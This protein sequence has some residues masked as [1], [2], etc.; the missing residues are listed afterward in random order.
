[1]YNSIYFSIYF[2]I[3][4]HIALQDIHI[5]MNKVKVTRLNILINFAILKFKI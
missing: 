3:I 1:M 2:Y 4:N 5:L